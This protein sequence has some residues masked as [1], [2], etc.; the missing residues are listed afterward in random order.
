MSEIPARLADAIKDHTVPQAPVTTHHLAWDQDS[1]GRLA[2]AVDGDWWRFPPVLK[3]PEE[4]DLC[5]FE[6]PAGF[7]RR[8]TVTVHR[9]A[10][11]EGSWVRR[12]A[13]EVLESWR[14][15]E[16]FLDPSARVA[17]EPDGIPGVE[18]AFGVRAIPLRTPTLPPATHTNC[19]VAGPGRG[20]LVVD[21]G[22]PYPEEQER[23]VAALDRYVGRHG[24]LGGIFLTHH[25]GDHVGG[26]EALR[27]TLG[28]PIL[29]HAKTA[30]KVSFS[31]DRL[32]EDGEQLGPWTAVF[33][34]GHAPGHLC[35]WHRTQRLLIA[36]DM[37]ASIGTIVVEPVDGDMAHYLASL[38]RMRQLD[39][40]ALYPAHGRMVDTPIQ[41]IDGY[42]AH[43]LWREQKVL[44]A[45]TEELSPLAEVTQRAYTDVAANILW[46]AQ[47]STMAHLKK[48]RDEGRATEKNDLW[49][50]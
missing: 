25:H 2:W 36:G 40:R 38:K 26:A 3:T 30:E 11:A 41:R 19:Y 9:S 17:I 22:S 20:A 7:D 47:W 12:S 8:R 42:T 35:L 46:L 16:I 14:R 45:L 4:R 6:T 15:A 34:P 32:V 44:E 43:R 18:N 5:G 29:A 49:C 10:A 13:A 21:P 28:L 37:I 1:Q 23:L 33:T 48:L 50:R 24:P 39:P 31:V 27:E